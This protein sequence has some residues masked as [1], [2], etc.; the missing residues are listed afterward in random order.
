LNP[1]AAIIRL[2]LYE[3]AVDASHIRLADQSLKLVRSSIDVALDI[4]A[5]S[6][7]EDVRMSYVLAPLEV[8]SRFNAN[9]YA[10]A[11]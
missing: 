4:P 11:I 10:L 7:V 2:R 9:A 5:H 1:G 8:G 3:D 6:H